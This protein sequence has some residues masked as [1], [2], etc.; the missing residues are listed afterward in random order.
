MIS[1]TEHDEIYVHLQVSKSIVDKAIEL[2]V[3]FFDTA[4]VSDWV[5]INEVHAGRMMDLMIESF[6][7]LSIG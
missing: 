4:E 5:G 1:H 6:L 7:H 2:G 3:N